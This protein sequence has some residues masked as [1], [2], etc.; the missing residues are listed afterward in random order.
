MQAT[1]IALS[2]VAAT[3]PL[4]HSTSVHPEAI[5]STSTAIDIIK[6][7]Y[8]HLNYEAGSDNYVIF[9]KAA[10]C[11]KVFTQQDWNDVLSAEIKK[12]E[13]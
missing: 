10:E 8:S 1:A 5:D 12:S 11:L 2:L 9:N 3:A 7:I 4:W 13:L 6:L